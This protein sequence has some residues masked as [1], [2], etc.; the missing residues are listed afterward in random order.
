MK[1]QVVIPYLAQLW[2]LKDC[3][4]SMG[5][6]DVPVLIV[7]NSADNEVSRLELPP[8]VEVQH[9]GGNVGVSAAWNIGLRK[10]AD[11]T[12]L[13]SQ[14][15]RFAPAELEWRKEKPWGLN[16]VAAGMEKYGTEYG[17]EFAGQGYHCISIGRKT[18]DTIGYIDPNLPIFGNDDDY[19]HRRHL[20]NIIHLMGIWGDHNESGVHSIAFAVHQQ[21]GTLNKRLDNFNTNSDQANYYSRKWCS[22]PYNYPGDYTHPFNNPEY[23]LDYFPEPEALLL[24]STKEG[25]TQ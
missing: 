2:C 25:D 17:M 16:H 20:A 3:V 19:Q 15:V 4:N 5:E 22:I 14:W 6:S 12:L 8:N 10:A 11:Q 9:F 23:G 7:D 21:N 24:D 1:L 18:V 13:L